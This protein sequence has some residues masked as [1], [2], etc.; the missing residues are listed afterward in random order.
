MAYSAYLETTLWT[1]GSGVNHTYYLD[2]DKMAAY[3]RDGTDTPYWFKSPIT[4][5]RS[6][7]KFVAVD[8]AVFLASKPVVVEEAVDE[9]VIEVAGS[10]PGSVYLVNT[11]EKT[12]T[13]QGFTY[14]GACKHV[15]DL[16]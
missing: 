2:G 4:I 10:K 3:L 6:R 7:R 9:A 14:R 5:S 13:C 12:C 11:R 15:K 16:E 8:S 1:D